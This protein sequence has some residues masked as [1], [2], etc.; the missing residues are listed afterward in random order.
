MALS[1]CVSADTDFDPTDGIYDPFETGNRKIHAFNRTIDRSI[2]RPAAQGYTKAVPDDIEESIGHF[3]TNLG[4]PSDVVNGLLQGD[5]N[6]AGI[7]T[8]RFLLNSTFGVAGLFDIATDMGLPDHETDFGETLHVWGAGEGPFVE[9]PLFG[10]STQR[11]VAGRIVD[12]FTN[13][14][15]YVL[16]EPE[17]YYSP[18]ARIGDGLGTRGRFTDTID[19]ILYE[20]ADS[21]AQSRLIYMQNRR[22][23]LGSEDASSEIDPFE[24]DTSGF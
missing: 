17:R 10:P 5:L 23:E 2:V 12:L 9:V 15:S 7:S 13:P 22:F 8:V 19:S 11:D 21:Y 20:S 24:L 16:D 3:A 6:G 1:A 4:R 14:L 18:A